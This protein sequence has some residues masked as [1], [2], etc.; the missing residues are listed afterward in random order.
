MSM[1]EKEKIKLEK[2][3]EF[4]TCIRSMREKEKI[5]LGKRKEFLT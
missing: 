5:K 2:G 1:K 4:V 3:K